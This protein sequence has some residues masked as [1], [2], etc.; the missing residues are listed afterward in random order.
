M[1]SKSYLLFLFFRTLN[2]LSF[3]IEIH[4]SIILLIR[5]N[6]LQH[7]VR[8][9]GIVWP[10]QFHIKD[11]PIWIM[12]VFFFFF[13][14]QECSIYRTTIVA[15]TIWKKGNQDI[16][17]QSLGHFLSHAE[18][19]SHSASYSQERMSRTVSVFHSHIFFFFCENF[20]DF[21]LKNE[22]WFHVLEN[23][24]E[25]FF[26]G[27]KWLF[28]PLL[29]VAFPRAIFSFAKLLTQPSSSNLRANI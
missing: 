21:I 12:K 1:Y 10:T 25:F 22:T 15:Y 27:K 5:K 4:I 23:S 7:L 16:H 8:Y 14:S 19:S 3:Y 2:L 18:C 29:V 20:H 6:S 9:I 13:L 17:C 28:W 24:R 26:P 11:R